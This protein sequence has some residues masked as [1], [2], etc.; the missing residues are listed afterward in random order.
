MYK[1]RMRNRIYL[2]AML[3]LCCCT[4]A[5]A[6]ASARRASMRFAY[7]ASDA[8]L[9]NPY[10]GNAVWAEDDAPH[11]QPFTLVY[12]QV[13]WAELEPEEGKFAFEA[14]EERAQMARWRAEGKRAILRFVMDVPGDRKH[15][16][17]PRWLYAATARKGKAYD[18]DYGRGCSPIYADTVLI[19][20]HARAIRALGER[21]GNDPFVAYMQLGS[22]G[23]WGEWHVHEDAGKFPNIAIC[24][25]YVKPYL[26]AF[27]GARLMMRRP[28][29]HAEK[30]GMGIYND[31]SALQGSTEEWLDWIANGGEFN[32][33][34][35]TDALV[36]MP[37]AWRTAPIG[38]E[39]SMEHE[40]VA[41]LG[42]RFEGTL[43]LF[44]RSHTSWIGPHSF[45]DIQRGGKQQ[46]NLDA[47]MR[48]IGYRL[49]VE[50]M[51]LDRSQ[52]D[53]LVVR[54]TWTNEGM[55]PFYFPWQA[56]LRIAGAEGHADY[57]LDLRLIDVLPGECV[58]V[59]TI[60]LR[61]DI[62]EGV[63]T[64]SVAVL[65]PTTG[66]PGVALAMSVPEQGLW[67]ELAQATIR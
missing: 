8:E 10:I 28:F 39:L 54:L 48:R 19:E 14:L 46:A 59:E 44:E 50:A 56:C 65:D 21:Y 35:E 60:V 2:L 16:D 27:P 62:P 57:P 4:A 38:G 15:M 67:Y 23:H 45:V 52:E 61:A 13:T 11:D 7:E 58:E 51:E 64:V 66:Q 5:S 34:G 31:T 24:E 6:H 1:R 32:E 25:Q 49:R 18:T 12:V 53:T 40:P 42:S 55:A 30:G 63:C 43:S 17:I 41:L 33:S 20:A 47:I 26:E 9:V 22:L 37:D 3:L 29:T 36:P